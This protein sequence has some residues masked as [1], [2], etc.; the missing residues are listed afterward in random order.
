MD[1]PIPT[2][3]VAL[4]TTAS[5]GGYLSDAGC[6]DAVLMSYYSNSAA[7]IGVGLNTTSIIT[8]STPVIWRA[9]KITH[10]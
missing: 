6:N 1:I 3:A 5:N 7:R 2:I 4:V 8:A 10:T 9:T